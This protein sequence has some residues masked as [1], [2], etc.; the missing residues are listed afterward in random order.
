VQ[1]LT[2]AVDDIDA[3]RNDLLAR[4]V[5]ISEVFHYARPF[6]DVMKN[7]RVSGRDPEN[8]SYFSLPRSRIR[9]ATVGGCKRSRSDFPAAN[10][11]QQ[12]NEHR[13][14]Q[15]LQISSM[16]LRSTTTTMRRPMLSTTGGIGTRPT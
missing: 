7:P 9:T 12:E 6:N 15:L 13:T 1:N 3:A 14:S 10:G 8:R 16:R 4:G 5:A 2:L 11:S